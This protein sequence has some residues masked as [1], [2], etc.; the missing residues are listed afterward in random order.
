MKN[1]E[2]DYLKLNELEQDEIRNKI[3]DKFDE[4]NEQRNSQLSHISAIRNAIFDSHSHSNLSVKKLNLP[5]AWEQASTLKAHL[6]EAIS[7]HPE[8][9]F[10]VSESDNLSSKRSLAHKL[11]LC[12]ALEKMKFSDK[13]ERIVDDLIQCGE[14]TLFVGYETRYRKKRVA[15]D[16]YNQIKNP[17]MATFEMVNEKIY[18]GTALNVVSAQ[19]FVF[20][21]QRAHNWEACPKI[22]RSYMEINEIFENDEVF[23]ISDVTKAQLKERLDRSRKDKD[24]TGISDGL[25]EVLKYWGNI[26]LND[27]KILKNRLIVVI[28]RLAVVQNETNPYIQ[29]PYIYAS[30]IQDP[31]TKRGLSPLSPILPV[32]NTASE[33]MQAQIK[34]L[35][36]VSNPPFLAP[37]GA[38]SGQIDVSPGKIIEYDPSLLPQMPQPLNFSQMLSG[39]DFIKFFKSQIESATGV[40]DN[41]AGQVSSH[42]NKTATEINYSAG[43]QNARLNWFIDAINRKIIIPLVEKTAT[44]NANFQLV[45]EKLSTQVDG[46]MVTIE[47]NS[48]IREGNFIYRYSDRKSA[49]SKN[50]RHKEIERTISEFAKVPE[51]KNKIN[52]E[53]CFKLSLANLGVENTSKFLRENTAGAGV[54]DEVQTP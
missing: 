35:K 22:H 23:T 38:F 14:V 41:M 8:G 2:F 32:L 9:L 54:E 37:R 24:I 1:L 20:D 47:I 4:L 48:D 5:D 33:I 10:D 39:W 25:V 40:Y 50:Q 52:F 16:L 12:N 26:R 6:L 46:K 31:I 11:Y 28:G 15:T 30:L 19:D 3:V 21:P 17:L 7:S 27:G 36:L 29:C 44:T 45:N 49:L 13:L 18:E 51:L 43:G 53:E 42:A 34:G